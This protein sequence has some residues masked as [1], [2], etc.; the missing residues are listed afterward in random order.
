MLADFFTK[1]LQG[2]LFRKFRAVILGYAHVDSLSPA[3]LDQE[4]VGKGSSGDSAVNSNHEE[5]EPVAD[6]RDGWREVMSKR[7][8]R[9][10]KQV[11][12]SMSG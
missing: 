5:G 12:K 10:R 4:R 1:P 9:Q 6:V 11:L 2:A 8:Q 7:T 3:P